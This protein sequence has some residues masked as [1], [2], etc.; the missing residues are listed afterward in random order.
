MK[1]LSLVFTLLSVQ[2]SFAQG[3]DLTK[4]FVGYDPTVYETESEVNNLFAGMENDFKQVNLFQL[5]FTGTQCTA[6]AET[7]VYDL[8]K[9][10]NVKSEKVFVFYT[11]AYHQWY[12]EQ[13]NKKFIWWFHVSPYVLAKDSN[14]NVE[15]LVMDKAFLSKPAGMKEWTDLFIESK[16]PCI[17]NVPYKNFEGDITGTGASYDK[18]A[19]CY[20]VRAPMYD[21]FPIDIYNREAVLRT[22]MDFDLDQ[23]TFASKSLMP[24]ARE[25]YLERTGL[26]QNN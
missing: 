14:G 19:H 6:R 1:F 15:E 18:N 10:K 21:M 8:Y 3:I 20:I 13:Q 12:R 7:W 11:L 4:R 16:Q 5:R 24:K 17:E 2:S 9:T 25:A 23:V 26:K 22:Q